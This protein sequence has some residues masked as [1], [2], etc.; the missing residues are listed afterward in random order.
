MVGS[1]NSPV[2]TRVGLEIG[3]DVIFGAGLDFEEA[4]CKEDEEDQ[5]AINPA[6]SGG[7]SPGFHCRNQGGF[8]LLLQRSILITNR[9]SKE[10]CW[11]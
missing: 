10:D 9:K 1:V 6:G 5:V 3:R 7:V 4:S 2:W 8:S 11:V